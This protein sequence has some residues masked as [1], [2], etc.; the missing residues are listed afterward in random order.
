MTMLYR[1]VQTRVSALYFS[2]FK[3]TCGKLAPFLKNCSFPKVLS[4]FFHRGD[5]LELES[6]GAL[7]RDTGPV[8]S[9][10]PLAVQKL[11]FANYVCIFFLAMHKKMQSS[12]LATNCW[13]KKTLPRNGIYEIEKKNIP[14]PCCI[15][16]VQSRVSTVRCND[17]FK[18][19]YDFWRKVDFSE[20]SGFKTIAKKQ[21]IRKF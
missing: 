14:Y 6:R 15:G 3:W 16:T 8:Y 5:L 18:I 19:L 21:S 10:T 1:P 13:C 4:G 2:A 20:S 11:W 9:G 17:Y 12:H 7:W